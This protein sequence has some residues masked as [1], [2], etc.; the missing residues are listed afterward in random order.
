MIFLQEEYSVNQS[1]LEVIIQISYQAIS[2]HL[3]KLANRPSPRAI[4]WMSC[5]VM[6]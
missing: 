4:S 6:S 3:K 1:K 5:G 2:C